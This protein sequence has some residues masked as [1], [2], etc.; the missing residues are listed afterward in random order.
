MSDYT[1]IRAELEETLRQLAA[2]VED[3]DANL[4]VPG[5][6]DWE[7]RAT[8]IEGDEVLSKLGNMSLDEMKQI[9]HALRRMDAGTY[10]KCETCGG[11]I[12]VGRLEALPFATTCVGCA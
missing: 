2:R 4:S 1:A 7:E 3:I 6:E 8:E 12:A 9:R 11:R 10:G 5:D